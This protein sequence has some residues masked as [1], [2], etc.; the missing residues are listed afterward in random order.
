VTKVGTAR[1]LGPVATEDEVWNPRP[2]LAAD[3]AAAGEQPGEAAAAAAGADVQGSNGVSSSSSSS[4][5]G[6]PV[7]AR[8]AKRK[9]LVPAA[10][11]GRS[12][13]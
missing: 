13:A 2:F 8:F 9:K 12:E 5:S 7:G 3:T 10:V 4:S 1:R 6:L 11:G